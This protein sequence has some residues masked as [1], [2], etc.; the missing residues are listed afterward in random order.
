MTANEYRTEIYKMLQQPPRPEKI[1]TWESS[2]AF[3]EV[4]GKA[5]MVRGKGVMQLQQIFS[6]LKGCY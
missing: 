6:Q 1:A 4:V 2:R 3:K 5:L